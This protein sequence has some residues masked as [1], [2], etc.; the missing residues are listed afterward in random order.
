[1]IRVVLVGRADGRWQLYRQPQWMAEVRRDPTAAG[2][3]RRHF[4]VPEDAHPLV[5]KAWDEVGAGANLEPALGLL[6][7]HGAVEV[8]RA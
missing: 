1:M 6:E 2:L 7:H 3:P 5:L 8:H 4:D